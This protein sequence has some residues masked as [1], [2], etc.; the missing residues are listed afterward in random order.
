MALA[1]VTVTTKDQRDTAVAKK[2][3]LELKNERLEDRVR[4]V[5]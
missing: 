5:S 1:T 4:C 3:K 2:M